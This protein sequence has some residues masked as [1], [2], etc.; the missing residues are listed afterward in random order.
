MITVWVLGDQLNVALGALADANPSTHRVLMV[1]SDAKLASQHWH[2]QRAHFVVASMRRFAA[3]LRAAGF[4][5][6]ERRSA[7]LAAGLAEHRRE[8]QPERVLATEPASRDGLALL[9]RLDVEVV[10]S[11]Q[12]VI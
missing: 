2:V 10:R 7:S 8:F 4:E 12:L 3:E 5:V 1:E 9:R 6:D 11:N